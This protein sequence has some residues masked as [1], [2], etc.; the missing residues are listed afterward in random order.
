MSR[1]TP[2]E[3]YGSCTEQSVNC[4]DCGDVESTPVDRLV[5]CFDVYSCSNRSSS[6]RDVEGYSTQSGTVMHKKGGGESFLKK[7]LY[8]RCF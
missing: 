7:E 1:A 8:V 2:V 3:L 4:G 6:C 5:S